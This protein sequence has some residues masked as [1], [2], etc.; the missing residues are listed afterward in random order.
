[1]NQSGIKGTII[2]F[3]GKDL[4]ISNTVL[5]TSKI[6]QDYKCITENYLSLEYFIKDYLNSDKSSIEETDSEIILKTKA[7][8]E[9]NKYIIYKTLHIDKKTEKPTKMIIQDVNLNDKVYILY[10][11]IQIM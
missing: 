6:F 1:M 4:K 8:N 5:S 2:E 3:N 7:L 11:E 9:D 10:N